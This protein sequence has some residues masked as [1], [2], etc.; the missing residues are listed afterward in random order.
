MS[1]IAMVFQDFHLKE[2]LASL[3]DLVSDDATVNIDVEEF[4]PSVTSTPIRQHN[5]KFFGDRGIL[6]KL[7]QQ[8][9]MLAHRVGLFMQIICS[10]SDFSTPVSK[11]S[12]QRHFP[13]DRFVVS[14]HSIDSLNG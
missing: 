5:V 13:Y 10:V 2:Q 4:K 11:G 9:P 12:K 1:V 14:L 6:E 7:Q 8:M 3:C